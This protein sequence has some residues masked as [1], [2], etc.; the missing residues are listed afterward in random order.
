MINIYDIGRDDDMHPTLIKTGSYN[1]GRKTIN[2]N[3]PLAL[4]ARDYMKMDKFDNEH[5]Y[6]IAFD[7]YRNSLGVF[8]LGIGDYKSCETYR[9]NLA[10][11]LILS[12]ARRF[13]IIHNHPDGGWISDKDMELADSVQEIAELFDIYFMG[14]YSISNKGLDGTLMDFP[15]LFDG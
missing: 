8:L 4:F 3:Y 6:L 1:V 15:I 2:G 13:L 12:G 10:E 7:Y 14:V 11:C 5:L 9:R